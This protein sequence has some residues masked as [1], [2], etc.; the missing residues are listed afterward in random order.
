MR[1]LDNFMA[2]WTWSE[3]TPGDSEWGK[4][5]VLQSMGSQRIGHK[6]TTEQQP[7]M[8][9]LF[10][11]WTTV[12]P[13]TSDGREPRKWV[14]WRLWLSTW[15][16]LPD[17]GNK[18]KN[19]SRTQWAKWLGLLEFSAECQPVRFV[20]RQTIGENPTLH[21]LKLNTSQNWYPS[22]RHVSFNQPEW[23]NF[24]DCSKHAA[25]AFRG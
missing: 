5:G 19:G 24:K 9:P 11:S 21:S 18:R 16:P 10:L 7:R 12:S 22:G 17:C 2:Q 13:V 23:R 3:Q 14:L 15:R 25:E 4:T 1:R 20:Q 6:L 8:K